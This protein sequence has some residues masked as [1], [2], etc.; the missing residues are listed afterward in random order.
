MRTSHLCARAGGCPEN[1]ARFVLP[2]TGVCTREAPMPGYSVTI[3][4]EEP[5]HKVATGVRNRR[6]APETMPACA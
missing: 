6:D 4:Y 5:M 2:G 3:R 1:P